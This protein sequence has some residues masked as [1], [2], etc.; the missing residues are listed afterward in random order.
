MGTA[1]KILVLVVDAVSEVGSLAELVTF[2]IAEE[3]EA[4]EALY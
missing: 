4:S 3:A 2:G 1:V